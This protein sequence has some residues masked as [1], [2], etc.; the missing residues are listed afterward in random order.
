MAD[1]MDLEDPDY[2]PI[3]S[4]YQ[5]TLDI[6]FT[7]RSNFDK[8]TTNHSYVEDLFSELQRYCA[9]S[10][11]DVFLSIG[12]ATFLTLLRYI[13]TIAIFTVSFI[14]GLYYSCVVFYIGNHVEIGNVFRR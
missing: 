12:L 3:P 6:Y 10:A 4:Y 14:A 5:C 1:A 13:L 8:M 2:L 7:A 9:V 11:F